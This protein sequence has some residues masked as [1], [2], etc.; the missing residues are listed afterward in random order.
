[1]V[2][3]DGVVET[4]TVSVTNSYSTASYGTV[5]TVKVRAITSGA[6]AVTNPG[7]TT[8]STL[9][10]AFSVDVSPA[11]VG[12]P[13][14]PSITSTITGNG[15]ITV[16]F[17]PPTIIGGITSYR[18]ETSTNGVLWVEDQSI[19]ATGASSYTYSGTGFT[20]GVTYLVRFSSVNNQGAGTGVVVTATPST[21]PNIPTSVTAGQQGSNAIISWVAPLING[22]SPLVAYVVRTT[23]SNGATPIADETIT[24]PS[25]TATIAIPNG[26]N[27]A[28]YS[29]KV[30]AVNGN[31]AGAF[32]G[33]VSPT[34]LP[35]R[36]QSLGLVAGNAQIVATWTA[37]I[38][39]SV[40][41]GY[42]VE[43]SRDSGA[44]WESAT[45]TSAT[46]FTYTYTGLT[47]GS[48]YYIR[49]TPNSAAGYGAIYVTSAV[50]ATTPDSPQLLSVVPNDP[51]TLLAIW[52]APVID[53]GSP[54]IGY[55]VEYK[56]DGDA[57]WT[58]FANTN[59]SSTTITLTGL[60]INS[61][62]DVRIAAINSA[63]TSSSYIATS[64]P[65]V[66]ASASSSVENLRISSVGSQS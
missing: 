29:F 45:S 60:T 2:T 51:G 37:P 66:V 48:R 9:Y 55:R 59:T 41:T 64:S 26:Q 23:A 22:G 21:T 28:Q 57:T 65:V 36:V 38:L 5:N 53:G 3:H 40:V 43:L 47:N 42:R 13:A 14:T 61:G 25:T 4:Q 1:V 31:G 27:I 34:L 63:G 39:N 50:P 24:V 33:A 19:S 12:A 49:I 54:V 11:S 16:Q 58:N 7:T 56:L 10:G 15:T 52:K 62:Y 18:V 6:T 46:T 32:S 20:N 30:R 35:D 17:A 8:T 44:T